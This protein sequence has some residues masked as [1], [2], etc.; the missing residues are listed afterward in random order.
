MKQILGVIL[1]ILSFISLYLCKL[2]KRNDKYFEWISIMLLVGSAWLDIP[3]FESG[4]QTI[5]QYVNVTV[6]EAAG[7]AIM[8][9][10]VL[11]VGFLFGTKKMVPAIQG[12]IL[13]H[14][15]W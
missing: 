9:A 15:F 6:K 1:I 5:T 4:N 3:L 2:T 8:L 11:S 12:C 13:G 14:L 10:Y 7:Y